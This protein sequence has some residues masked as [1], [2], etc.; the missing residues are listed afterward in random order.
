[1]KAKEK[2]SAVKIVEWNTISRWVREDT[3]PVTFLLNKYGTYLGTDNYAD[4]RIHN[5]TGISFEHPWTFYEKIEPRTV[6][7]DGGIALHGLALGQGEAQLPS[8]QPLN[9]EQDRSLWGVMRWQTA[10][11]LNVDYA[12]SLRL[13]DTQGQLVHQTDDLIW[14][15]TD[16]CAFEQMVIE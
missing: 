2:I 9:L 15:S 14:H 12:M 6:L 3:T 10:P 13:Y 1:M 4:F 11:E 8:L 5:F 7:Y 16:P